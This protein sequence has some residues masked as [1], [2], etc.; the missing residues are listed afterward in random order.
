MMDRVNSYYITY[1]VYGHT[2]YTY[3]NISII[4]QPSFRID[5]RNRLYNLYYMRTYY[6]YTHILSML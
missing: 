4:D 1:Y 5:V 2:Y 3:T 6:L